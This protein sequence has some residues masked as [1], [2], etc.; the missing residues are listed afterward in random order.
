MARILLIE[1]QPDV[2]RSLVRMLE[3]VD[4]SVD[5]AGDGREALAL[6]DDAPPDLVITDIN[7]PE[8]DG[9]EFINALRRRR[10]GVPVIAMTG[11]GAL[12]KSLLLTSAGLL[13]AV[14][15]LEKPFRMADL[16]KAVV[17]ALLA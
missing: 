16:H 12:D 17:R 13:G 6:F 15:R 10:T 14:E 2:R 9:L 3:R 5:E 11:G 4:H 7:M 8:M 1:D